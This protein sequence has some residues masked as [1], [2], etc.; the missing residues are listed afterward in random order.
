MKAGDLKKHLLVLG[1][2]H[3]SNYM[4]EG[5]YQVPTNWT[6]WCGI[7]FCIDI[8]KNSYGDVR[9]YVDFS[10][11]GVNLFASHKLEELDFKTLHT[12]LSKIL[13]VN[14]QEFTQWSK[15]E[16]RDS[17]LDQLL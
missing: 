17:K 9:P 2:K 8:T 4:V 6:I 16:Y 11:G 5:R 1:F 7:K 14:S 15:I 10:L 12:E 3:N 13:N